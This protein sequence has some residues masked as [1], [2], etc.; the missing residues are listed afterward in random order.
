M[1]GSTGQQ[2][3][4]QVGGRRTGRRDQSEDTIWDPNN[5]WATAEGV[6]PVVLP[7]TV[8]QIDPGP[9]IGLG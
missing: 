9:A 7:P 4:G 5:P 3:Y 6:D 8:Q 2:T 1:S